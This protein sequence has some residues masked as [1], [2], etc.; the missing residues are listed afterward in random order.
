MP[1]WTNDAEERLRD[2]AAELFEAHGYEAVTVTA[3]AEQAGLTRRTFFRYF[4]DKREVLFP[5]TDEIGEAVAQAINIQPRDADA[6]VLVGE[7]ITVLVRAGTVITSDRQAQRKRQT[8]IQSSPELRE[9]SRTKLATTAATIESALTTRGEPDAQIIAAV[10]VDLLRTAYQATL[11]GD[12]DASFAEHVKRA[13]TALRSFDSY[14][15]LP[16][17]VSDP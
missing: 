17:P 4:P 13:R 1:R 15:R 11:E 10:A 6:G 5:Q 9:R 12:D 2:A 14:S 8:L 3:I 16:A 7:I